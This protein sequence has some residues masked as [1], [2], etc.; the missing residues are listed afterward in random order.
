[1]E[2]LEM[3]ILENS[4]ILSNYFDELKQ[5]IDKLDYTEIHDVVREIFSAYQTD[6]KILI[7]GNG[8]SAAL[9]NHMATDLTN[10]IAKAA[11]PKTP[12]IRAISLVSNIPVITAIANDIDYDHIFDEQINAICNP[13][14]VVIGISGSGRSENVINALDAAFGVGAVTVAMVG[15]DGGF[16][17]DHAAFCIHVESDSYGIIEDVHLSVNHVIVELFKEYFRTVENGN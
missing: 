14:D 2:F 9:A 1:M 13:G 8:G 4:N 12:K 16:V 7:C 17:K 6:H 3:E 5:T 15:M 10:T 11:K